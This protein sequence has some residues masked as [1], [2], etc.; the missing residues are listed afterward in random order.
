MHG[1][2]KVQ[3]SCCIMGS[4]NRFVFIFEMVTVEDAVPGIC[5][6]G[7]GALMT[8]NHV[9]VGLGGSKKTKISPIAGR[10]IGWHNRK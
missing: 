10:C 1:E 5:T 7:P 8:K 9:G 6:S 2:G 4:G 3:I